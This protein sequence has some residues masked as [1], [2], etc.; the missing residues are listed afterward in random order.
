MHIRLTRWALVACA[1]VLL[2]APATSF[3][4]SY[5]LQKTGKSGQ[6]YT[7]TAGSC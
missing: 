6:T 4:G 1:C 3:A 7:W 5:T 2:L